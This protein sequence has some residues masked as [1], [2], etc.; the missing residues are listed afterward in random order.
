MKIGELQA[1]LQ[2]ADALIANREREMTD[3]RR[4]YE[5]RGEVIRRLQNKLTE[6]N[7]ALHS[8]SSGLEEREEKCLG[9]ESRCSL[10]EDLVRRSESELTELKSGI[11]SLAKSVK[12]GGS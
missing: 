12:G 6:M 11:L 10:L 5:G 9:M 1:R 8:R 7:S 3:L 4:L 2:Q